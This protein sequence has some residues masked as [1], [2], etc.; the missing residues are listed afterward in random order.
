MH[1]PSNF[2]DFVYIAVK[3]PNVLLYVLRLIMDNT[4]S[5][6]NSVIEINA[7]KRPHLSFSELSAFQ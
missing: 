4:S 3:R 6:Y 1:F 7:S 5:T 2:G